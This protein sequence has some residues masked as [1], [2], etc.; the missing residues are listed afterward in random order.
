LICVHNALLLNANSVYPIDGSATILDRQLLVINHAAWLTQTPCGLAGR[1]ERG[2]GALGNCGVV[3]KQLRNHVRSRGRMFAPELSWDDGRAMG[4]IQRA[5]RRALNPIS[6]RVTMLVQ[7]IGT[8]RAFRSRRRAMRRASATFGWLS[9]SASAPKPGSRPHGVK[10]SAA[11]VAVG[12]AEGVVVPDVIGLA[13][14]DART[15]LHR[16]GLVAVGP[17]PDGPPLAAVGWPDGVVVDQR[18]EPGAVLPSGAPVTL[19]IER[20][21]GSAGVREPRS[22]KPA[23][24]AASGMIDEESDEAVG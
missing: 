11:P 2:L 10:A 6:T 12:N 7:G 19:W 17:D 23:P 9:T 4:A 8:R 21:G 24:R 18:P 1:A 16:T 20:G 14:D 22:P 13:W 5:V 3:S 15:V